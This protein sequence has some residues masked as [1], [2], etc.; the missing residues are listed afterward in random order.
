[1]SKTSGIGHYYRVISCI[2]LF[3]IFTIGHGSGGGPVHDCPAPTSATTLAFQSNLRSLLPF[4]VE[5]AS[6]STALFHN[7]STGQGRDRVY[8]RA[9]CQSAATCSAC[10][11]Q[12]NYDALQLC[13]AR[14]EAFLWNPLSLCSLQ[15]GNWSFFGR[16]DSRL[17]K[18]GMYYY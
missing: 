1:M 14:S 9:V 7:A 12:L 18:N 4:L 15:Y 6:T 11:R 17:L 16:L 3:M 10:L 5:R 8:G 2:E 13:P